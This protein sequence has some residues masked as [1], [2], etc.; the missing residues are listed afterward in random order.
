MS[1]RT[2]TD[3]AG[4]APAG[5]GAGETVTARRLPP[6][7]RWARLLDRR[8]LWCVAG[9]YLVLRL[10]SAVVMQLVAPH[11]DLQYVFYS[12][13]HQDYWEMTHV[14]DGRWYQEIAEHGYPERLPE[15]GNGS[16]DQN[17]W[18]FYP[19][20]PAL[21]H[22]LMALTGGS[23]PVVGSL[24]SLVLGLVAVLLMAVLLREK[25]GATVA[26]CAVC[27]FAA[28]PPSPVLQMTYTESLALVL[29]ITALIGLQ[30][31]NWWLAAGAALLCGVARPI[32]VPLA[33]VALVVAWQRWQRR[34][35]EPIQRREWAGI[36]AM[37][38]ACGLSW[39]IW[40]VTAWVVTGS[41]SAYTDTMAGW[42]ASGQLTYFVPWAENFTRLFGRFGA[43]FWLVVMVVGFL[44]M[45]LGPWAA[46]LGTTMRTWVLAYGLYLLAVLD[47]WT[48]TYRYLLFMFPIAVI[49]I[50]AG[51]QQR[52]KNLFV[53]WRTVIWVG[54]GLG[55]QVW[56]CWT[57]LVL[58]HIGSDPI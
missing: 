27:V 34:D 16:V 12:T 15:N 20:Y 29:L 51:W 37:L 55:W 23:F 32:A 42:R 38:T 4:A 11:Q 6:A 35:R 53:G 14:W 41:P 3:P 25:V 24:L 31:H 17:P 48:S 2:E 56:W 44:A 22:V 21:V 57:L 58:T 7:H 39:A 46:A 43:G 8:L 26:F 47:A 28:S 54:L 18:A 13:G 19:L 5:S 52:S 45:L 9:S 40:P 33:L 36:G 49:L 1:V 50:G 10:F 30:R